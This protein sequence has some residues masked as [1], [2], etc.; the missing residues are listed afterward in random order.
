MTDAVTLSDMHVKLREAH[1]EDFDI[2][3]DLLTRCGLTT[4][5]VTPEGSTYWIADLDGVPGGCIGLEH[6]DGVSLIRSTAVVPEA[7]NQGLGRA[8]VT[9]ALTQAS[10][11]GHR[12]VYLFSEEAGDYWRRFGFV[13]AQP[14]DIIAALP[15]APQVRSG[16]SKGW[17]HAEQAWTCA[18]GGGGPA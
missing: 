18:L 16:L 7:R 8:L 1:A 11:L 14:D 9:S 6:G 12:A 2:I 15:D 13:P 17:I 5:S 4:G 10:L 3:R